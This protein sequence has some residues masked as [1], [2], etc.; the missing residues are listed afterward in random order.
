MFVGRQ[1]E[2]SALARQYEAERSAFVPIYGRRRVG[3]SE[4]IRQFTRDRPTIYHV[5]RLAPAG[6]LIR[7]FQR[8][9]ARVLDEPLLA[10]L[11]A[12]DWR[13][14]LELVSRWREDRKLVVVLDE[15]Q[16]TA[17]SEPGLAGLLQEL[18]DHHWRDSGRVFLILCG[19]FVGFMEREVLGARAPLFGRRTA[20]IRLPP[21]PHRD[22]AR[23]HP[24]WSIEH[25]AQAYFICGGIPAYLSS[26]DDGQSIEANVCNVLLSELGVLRREPEF[27]LR[28]ELREVDRYHA[29]L[30]AIAG[31]S[32]APREIAQRAGLADPASVQY[33]L[34]QLVE[35][36]YVAKR[37]P[38]RGE[39]PKRTDV[40]YVLDDPLLRFWFRFV[41]PNE[42]EL[43]RSRE[44]LTFRGRIRPELAAYFGS[45]FERLCRE[46]LP[47]LYEREGVSAGYR[48]GEYWDKQVQIDVVGLRDDGWT[49]IGE[50]KWG[51]LGSV[52]TVVKELR[53]K[54]ARFPNDRGASIGLRAFVR[55]K[56]KAAERGITWHSLADLYDPDRA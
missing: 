6:L 8:Q 22:A 7:D 36:G 46:A 56:P 35:L 44:R 23:L 2:L 13:R 39:K 19:S 55:R 5:G 27:L 31:G 29:V 11:P 24:R 47:D 40:R 48:V 50:C 51:P 26:F 32:H 52:P 41:F 49:D 1:A 15:F 14:A 18:W 10:E 42:S 28:E 4:L 20:Q 43:Q 54:A 9:V 3:K 53:S 17:H 37:Y 33:Y 12:N 38:L 21:L 16:W 45:C 30:L 34:G 25:Q